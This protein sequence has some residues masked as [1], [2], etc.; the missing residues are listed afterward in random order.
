M[1]LL[2]HY[3]WQQ[4][5]FP[6][7][8]L[9]TTD[10]QAVE[11]IN[12]GLHNHNAGP[13]FFNAK[14][15]IGDTMWVGNVEIHQ[16]SSDW[17]KHGHDKDERYKNV[18]LHVVEHADCDILVDG[19]R[20]PQMELC[21][22]E[23][24]KRRYNELLKEEHYPPC[25]RCIPNIPS[26]TQRQWLTQLSFE[27]LSQKMERIQTYLE[28][29]HNDWEQTLFITIARNFGFGVNNEAFERWAK[30]T[31]LNAMRKHRHNA[32]QT[33]A[34]FFG[35]AGLLDAETM[36]AHR[37]DEY[38]MKL[39][40]EF[41]F[42]KHKFNLQ[43]IQ[44]SNWNFLRMRPQ[45][46][47]Y[48][49]LSQLHYLYQE[50]ELQFA[51]I[52]DAQYIE[53]LYELLKTQVSGY[54]TTHFTFGGTPQREQSRSLN[55]STIQLLII[56]TIAPLLYCY[57]KKHD[58]EAIC[59]KAHALL[60]ELKAE[61]NFIT[62]AWNEVGVKAENAADSQAMIQLQTAYCDRKDCLRC[63]FGRIYMSQSN[64]RRVNE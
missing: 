29:T 3:T 38:F 39:K 63:R 49:R 56:N 10:G 26:I 12:V 8:D 18:V 53:D 6:L 11:V 23:E 59:E 31:P 1:E 34:L 62:R 27:R 32:F 61:S 28:A 60:E 64:S 42:L 52:L 57:G 4:R 13:D 54:W 36:E 45:N 50:K 20:V 21:A 15:K 7:Q 46:F 35:T 41:D 33:E 30:I 48:S 17:Y 9:K 44:K 22:P 14:V 25:Y 37:Q 19:V 16:C 2:L 55:K 40:K 51:Q 47:V 5:M 24:V 58:N 43:P